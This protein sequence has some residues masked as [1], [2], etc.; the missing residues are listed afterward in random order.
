MKLLGLQPEWEIFR[1]MW[2]DFIMG[3]HLNLAMQGMDVSK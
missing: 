1:D 3:K 2:K